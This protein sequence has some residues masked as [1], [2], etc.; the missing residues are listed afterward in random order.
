MNDTKT[1]TMIDP[2]GMATEKKS[3]KNK[4]ITPKQFAQK[5]VKPENRLKKAK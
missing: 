4:K 1:G 5:Y 2:R 3:K